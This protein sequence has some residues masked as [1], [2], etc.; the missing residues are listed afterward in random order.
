[1]NNISNFNKYPTTDLQK[2][3]EKTDVNHIILIFVKHSEL[4][5]FCNKVVRKKKRFSFLRRISHH[6]FFVDKNLDFLWHFVNCW[7]TTAANTIESKKCFKHLTTV[8]HKR[9]KI[10]S[11]NKLSYKIWNKMTFRVS[12][13]YFSANAKFLVW[14]TLVKKI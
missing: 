12:H 13:K 5:T 2:K 8:L 11:K 3:K 14:A 4:H 1:M 6:L 7:S 10:Y 9:E